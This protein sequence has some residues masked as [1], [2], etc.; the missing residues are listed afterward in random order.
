LKV[1]GHAKDKRVTKEQAALAAHAK[2]D[3]WERVIAGMTDGTLSLRSSRAPLVNV[4]SWATLEVATGGFATGRMLASLQPEDK[5]NQSFL[6]A[7]GTRQLDDW[8]DNGKYRVRYPEH[9]ALLVLALYIRQ[10]M[11][12]EADTLISEISPF[13]ETLRFYP[14]SSDTQLIVSP[15]VSVCNVGAVTSTLINVQTNSTNLEIKRI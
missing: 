7:E 1:R 8:L 14:D 12:A 15:L 11:I 9:A 6:T 10:D 3:K 5:T 4:P 13:F 2:T